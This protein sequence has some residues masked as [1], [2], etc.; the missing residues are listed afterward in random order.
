MDY[1]QNMEPPKPYSN[2][3]GPYIRE[4][5]LLLSQ[6]AAHSGFQEATLQRSRNPSCSRTAEFTHEG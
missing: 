3:Q 4:S 2:Y 6:E 1:N 5:E